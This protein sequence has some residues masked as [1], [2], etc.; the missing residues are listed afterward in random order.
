MSPNSQSIWFLWPDGKTFGWRVADYLNQQ[1]WLGSKL[2]PWKN[3]PSILEEILNGTSEHAACVV[4][5]SNNLWRHA[6]P[7]VWEMMTRRAR[8][9]EDDTNLQRLLPENLV[10]MARMKI[11]QALIWRE[12]TNILNIKLI[13][14]H[15]ESA[16]QVS[17]WKRDNARDA[18][19][20][21][22]E[23][24]GESIERAQ[25]DNDACTVAIWPKYWVCE[26][27][28][29]LWEGIQNDDINSTSFA[30]I[31]NTNNHLILPEREKY[32]KF[33]ILAYPKIGLESDWVLMFTSM[34]AS[35]WLVAYEHR[36]TNS[37]ASWYPVLGTDITTD[38]REELDDIIADIQ[39]GCPDL[40]IVIS[41]RGR[42]TQ[43]IY[44]SKK[45]I[46]ELS[47]LGPCRMYNVPV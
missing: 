30:L 28:V 4:A 25:Q 6:V 15:P 42:A 13:Y 36:V 22:T 10:A 14:A 2:V 35:Y 5:Y 7:E 46:P 47:Y 40:K 8:T 3:Q 45:G 43:T 21:I 19:F 44:G 16:N 17:R 11:E 31:Q 38:S 41:N 26:G 29:V 33:G 27:Q 23:S 39:R 24:N 18:R 34:L 20:I 1:M 32:E 12:D 9:I 37:P